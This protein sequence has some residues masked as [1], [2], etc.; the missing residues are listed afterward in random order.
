[1][2]YSPLMRIL[3]A[4]VTAL[5]L[6]WAAQPPRRISFTRAGVGPLT[7]QLFISAADGSDEHPLLAAPQGEYDAVWAPGG[8]S[9]VFTSDRNGSGDLF[10]VDADGSNLTQLTSDPAYEDQAAFSPDGNQLVFVSTRG[11]GYADLWTLD[12]ATKNAKALTFGPGGDY[13]PAWS[14]DGKW[15]A[16]SSSRG[17]TAPFAEGRWERLQLAEIYL[18]RPDGSA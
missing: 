10:R 5:S 4:A 9:I 15:I 11:S 18:I 1:M 2:W 14:P 8:Q 7:L 13:R 12:L 17:I 3:P 6:L 16:F